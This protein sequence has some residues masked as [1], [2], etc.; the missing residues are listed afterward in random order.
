M[1]FLKSIFSSNKPST[2]S[3]SD[4]WNWF[5]QHEK[6]FYQVIKEQGDIKTEFFD[7]MAPKLDKLKDGIYFLAGMYDEDTAELIFTVDGVIKNIV[8]AEE[9]VDAAPNL[10][11]WK[12]TALKQP[13]KS[14]QY[15][16]ELGGYKFDTNQMSFFS[17]NHETMP[18]EIDISIAHQDL[19]EENKTVVTNGVYLTLDNFIGELNSVTTIDILNVIHPNDASSELIPLE[20]LKD[21]L[22]W[23]EKE[24]VEK[25]KG[26]R[27]NTENDSYSTYQATLP[28][29][30]SLIAI[31]NTDLLHWDSKASHPWIAVLDIKYN[32]ENNNG[33]PDKSTYERLNEIE[34][35]ILTKLKD[36]DGYLNIGRETAD[37]LRQ[38]YFA[39]VEFRKPSKVFY[40][41]Q[42]EFRDS[43]DIDYKI[44]KDKYWQSFNRFNP[45]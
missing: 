16:I 6:A 32:G 14:N 4:F 5:E 9:L 43:F 29:E 39:C 28:N 2:S 45:N 40:Q 21:F 18:D 1:N 17:T 44:Y 23:R 15:I 19:N 13:A 41:I 27:H 42:Q 30:L 37:S 35:K 38:V 12:F 20:K 31:M 34:D 7:K 22:T 26:L 3:Y 8:F 33:L 11:H 24:F 36:A 10:P 25:Y